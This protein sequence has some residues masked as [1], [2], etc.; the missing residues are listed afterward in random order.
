MVAGWGKGRGGAGEGRGNL[1]SKIY[2]RGNT[3]LITEVGMRLAGWELVLSR[4]L[5]T[6]VCVR[7]CVSACV[8]AFLMPK[9]FP[10]TPTNG[11]PIFPIDIYIP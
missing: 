9:I 11:S 6:S 1:A 3:A 7:V 5:G 2:V 8:R 10:Y 4:M